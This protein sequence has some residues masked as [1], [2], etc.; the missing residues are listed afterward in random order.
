MNDLKNLKSVFTGVYLHYYNGLK[1]E[2][3]P[4]PKFE[5]NIT[6]ITKLKNQRF[7]EIVKNEK[8][9]NHELFR[10][11]FEY[12]RPSGMYKALKE[13]NN[14]KKNKVQVN[15]IPTVPDFSGLSR[16]QVSSHEV[17][18]YNLIV[19]NNV[20][21]SSTSK[22]NPKLLFFQ[23]INL[24]VY[25]LTSSST[26]SSTIFKFLSPGG[27]VYSKTLLHQCFITLATSFQGL[28]SWRIGPAQGF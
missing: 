15:K 25:K 7:N 6:E 3:E 17:P 1:S 8:T 21:F 9:I 13:I 2:P 10:K 4:E 26:A 24:F 28:M 27:G 5:K 22:E 11:Y 19:P 20:P 16:N 23:S 12:S 14:S 18:K